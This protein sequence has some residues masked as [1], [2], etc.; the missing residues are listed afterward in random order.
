MSVVFRS[1]NCS[2]IGRIAGRAGQRTCEE[3]RH[4]TSRD[5]VVKAGE[6]VI[7]FLQESVIVIAF[8]IIVVFAITVANTVV[9]DEG[10]ILC[11][12]VTGGNYLI[13]AGEEVIY[14]VQEFVIVVALDFVVVFAVAVANTVVFRQQQED[15]FFSPT[16]KLHFISQ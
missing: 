3:H 14:F 9:I 15:A 16:Q 1:I 13:K 4:V 12:I 7:Y 10:T 11:F 6:E 2:Q 5:D 8:D